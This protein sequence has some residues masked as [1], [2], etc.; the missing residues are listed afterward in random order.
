[1]KIADR[2][3]ISLEMAFSKRAVALLCAAAL[4]A[5]ALNAARVAAA[6]G[7]T[8][9]APRI[10]AIAWADC[11]YGLESGPAPP[12]T[13]Y[14]LT[15]DGVVVRTRASWVWLADVRAESATIGPQRFRAIAERLDRSTIFDPPRPAS[16]LPGSH[17]MI[18]IGSTIPS[19]TRRGRFA[20]RRDG[21]WHDWSVYR[22]FSPADEAAVGA[23]YAAAY[24][25]KL[26][27]HPAV[28]RAN[29]FA[30]CDL[31][32]PR[33]AITVPASAP[34][35]QQGVSAIVVAECRL[36]RAPADA[37]PLRAYRLLPDGT[38]AR[39]TAADDN[40]RTP[41]VTEQA[42][43]GAQTFADFGTRLERAGFFRDHRYPDINAVTARGTRLAAVRGNLRMMW[44][45]D[46]YSADADY[47]DVLAV[48]VTAVSD[49]G[50]AWRPAP[51]ETT[52]FAI[53][54]R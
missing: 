53:C 25:E 41:R 23:A 50:L 49:S 7:P 40:A 28:P 37:T 4:T 12:L 48:I 2:G 19:D 9:A 30:M 45:S 6:A 26:T 3:G 5:G 24:D 29:A 13:S 36:R 46:H 33:D 21:T 51:L 42:A 27:W 43:I 44:Q 20:V 39:T 10:T 32:E 35:L 34:A 14:V 15:P 1:M 8:A 11:V 17:G 52:A 16:P 47:A 22:E 18:R 54:A 31:D 38:V